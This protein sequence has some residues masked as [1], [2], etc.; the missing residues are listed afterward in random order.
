MELAAALSPALVKRCGG[1]ASA[2]AALFAE[3]GAGRA[4]IDAAH[5]GDWRLTPALTAH[6]RR[7]ASAWGDGGLLVVGDAAGYVEPFTGEGITWAWRSADDASALVAS[8]LSG[9]VSAETAAARWSRRCA[10]Q[11]MVGRRWCRA[12][13]WML[14]RPGLV[15]GLAD[16]AG[17]CG[18]GGGLTRR[19][20]VG[21]EGALRSAAGASP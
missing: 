13:R 2:V 4:W 20:S 7:V 5:A 10:V 6:R 15:A 11:R 3:A 12:T 17:W 14:R 9:A 1:A 18:M 19:G 16:V 8:A 21:V